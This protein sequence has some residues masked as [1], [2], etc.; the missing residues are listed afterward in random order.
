ML[1]SCYITIQASGQIN[2][3]KHIKSMILC[4]TEFEAPEFHWTG[5]HLKI[6]DVLHP[7]SISTFHVG[8]GLSIINIAKLPSRTSSNANERHSGPQMLI[9]R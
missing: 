3:S 6:D 7:K 8:Y 4:V 9:I 5:I 2:W 1:T